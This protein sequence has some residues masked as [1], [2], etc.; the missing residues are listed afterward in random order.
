MG[1][2]RSRD[3]KGAGSN[4][5]V[6]SLPDKKAFHVQG[7]PFQ[8][9]SEF[10]AL[11]QYAGQIPMNDDGKDVMFFW[12]V[13]NTTNTQNKDKL[14]LWLNGG[15]G[16]TSLD[17]V[18][19][20]NGPY[21]FDGPNR[22]RFRD[23][24]FSQQFDV[25][26]ID[27]PFGTGFSVANARDYMTS[28]KNA[29]QSLVTFLTKFYSVFP[30][31]RQ[32]QLYISGESEA[33]TY[34]PYLADAILKMPE[35]Q[36]FNLSGVL[37]GNGWID[38]YPMYMS[39]VELLRQKDMLVPHIQKKMIDQ[40]DLCARQ[41]KK[42]PQPVHVEVCEEIPGIFIEQGGPTPNHCYNQY[43]LRLTDTQPACG[44]N[45]PPEIGMY[46][47][48][49][50][51]KNV[52]GAINIKDGMAPAIWTECSSQV[53]RMLKD[54]SSSPASTLLENI[55]NHI[56]IL[57]FVGDADFL[58]NYVGIEWMIGNLTWAGSKGLSSSAK[59]I[60]WKINGAAAGKISSDRGLTYVRIYNAS[61][62]VGVDKPR[63]MLDLFTE[64]T[65]SS[66]SNL[67]FVSS[68]SLRALTGPAWAN[69]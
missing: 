49:L 54:D 12:L 30:E 24:S 58:C 36:R 22:L 2:L 52:Q 6:A 45:W 7:I 23:Y 60:D 29:T 20:E 9:G 64:F 13:T 31:Y 18:F 42:A 46:N 61:H 5:T 19:L 63:E 11:E 8:D 56:P 55:L 34:L 17:G 32:R 62:M 47:D 44:M 67:H 43:D 27:Q 4:K 53:N 1:L 33:G 16:C 51:R 65:N 35:G 15:P 66:A 41:Y 40:M 28:F 21:K 68:L 3:S 26:Y 59:S 25:L 57:L 48:Y 38:P 69:G 10:N 37:I 50:N 39:Y 14:V